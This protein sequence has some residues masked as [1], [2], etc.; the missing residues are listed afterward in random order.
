VGDHSI[1]RI[2]QFG[3]HQSVFGFL[4]RL[5]ITG[6]NERRAKNPSKAMECQDHTTLALVIIC[7]VVP[8]WMNKK[9]GG[10]TPQTK[11]VLF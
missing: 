3:G 2:L 1:V 7:R 10:A 9:L 11:S 8:A 4:I 5:Y 6:A